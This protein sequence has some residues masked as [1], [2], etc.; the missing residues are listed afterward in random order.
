MGNTNLKASDATAGLS[1]NFVEVVRAVEKK[2]DQGGV[3][4]NSP[5]A[6]N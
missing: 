5:T 3:E 4:I 1:L 2:S 6:G